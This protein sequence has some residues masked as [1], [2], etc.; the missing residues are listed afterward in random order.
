M[1]KGRSRQLGINWKE[2]CL[3]ATHGLK[4]ILNLYRHSV[5]FRYSWNSHFLL[6]SAVACQYSNCWCV[7]LITHATCIF[8]L[9]FPMW[10]PKPFSS[11]HSNP[12]GLSLYRLII[13]REKPKI[14][15]KICITSTGQS[16]YIN[17]TTTGLII[18]L[19]SRTK[20]EAKAAHQPLNPHQ[21]AW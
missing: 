16:C 2:H 7:F 17:Y 19:F 11:G 3:V 18:F 5:D 1:L 14:K 8:T 12:A 6:A 13:W 4:C 10:L 21:I 20:T 15:R 9:V